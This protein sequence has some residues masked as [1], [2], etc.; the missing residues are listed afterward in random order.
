M[1]SHRGLAI[2]TVALFGASSVA[3]SIQQETVLEMQPG[4]GLVLAVGA[5]PPQDMPLE[6][7]VVMNIDISIGLLDLLFGQIG[8]DVSIGDLL[9]ATPPFAFLGIPTLFTE[10]VCVVTQDGNPGGGTFDANLYGKTA[11]FDVDINTIA[12]LGNEALAAALPGGGL[13]FPFGM[14]ATIPMTLG[15][16]L[17]MLTGSSDL[18][19]TQDIDLDLVLDVSLGGPPVSL[20]AHVGGQVTLA[21]V[22]AFPTGPLLDDCIAFLNE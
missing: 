11:T 7:G 22:D 15:D 2:L 13:A 5:F 1:R 14:Q 16:M 10:E 9:F 12:L 8:G 3:C 20:P 21:S 4:S 17:G 18:E 6:G 19:V